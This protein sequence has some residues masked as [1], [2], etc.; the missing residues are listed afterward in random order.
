MSTKSENYPDDISFD[1]QGKP[2]C[3]AGY[4]M[5]PWGNDPIKDAHKYR[6]PLKCG[7]IES[8]PCAAECVP[9]KKYGRTVYVKNEGDLR[10]HPAIPRDSQEYKDI[11]SERTACER[12]NNRVLNDYQLQF[13]KIRGID[14]FSF[15][16]ML[17]GICIHLDARCKA[18][19]LWVAS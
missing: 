17:I 13:L 19:R 12:V 11:Y 7:R 2:L 5:V 9:E 8:C 1:K 18:A 14:H 6:C 15:W 16:T 3:R 4:K 10:F